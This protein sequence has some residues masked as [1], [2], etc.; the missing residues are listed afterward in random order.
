MPRDIAGWCEFL[1]ALRLGRRAGASGINMRQ[2]YII[3]A[4]VGWLWAVVFF[5]MLFVYLKLKARRS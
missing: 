1:S 5:V 4:R 2:V 3:F